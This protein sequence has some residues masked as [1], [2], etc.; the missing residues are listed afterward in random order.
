MT[1]TTVDCERA[2]NV[3][4]KTVFISL[5]FALEVALK[6]LNVEPIRDGGVYVKNDGGF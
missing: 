6:K 4:F 1:K 2:G 3:D 5:K